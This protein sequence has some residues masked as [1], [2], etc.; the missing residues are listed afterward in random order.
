[1]TS[2]ARLLVDTLR[3]LTD[4]MTAYGVRGRRKLPATPCW[5]LVNVHVLCQVPQLRSAIMATKPGGR[6]R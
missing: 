3:N 1:M 6:L 2:R 5:R 4:G